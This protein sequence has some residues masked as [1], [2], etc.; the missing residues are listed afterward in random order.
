MDGQLTLSIIFNCLV[1][2]TGRIWI[3]FLNEN[4]LTYLASLNLYK[5]YFKL[6][7][8]ESLLRPARDVKHF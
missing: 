2:F 1:S 6:E 5:R 8:Y 3:C 4:S 7:K